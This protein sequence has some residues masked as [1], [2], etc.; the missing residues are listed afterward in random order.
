M[1]S[2][3]QTLDIKQSNTV[4]FVVTYSDDEGKSLSLE[5][6]TIEADIKDSSKKLVATMKVTSLSDTT[7]ELI[8]PDDVV[9]PL[10]TL[11]M[12]IRFIQNEVVRNSDIVQLNVKEVVT[13]G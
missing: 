4:S 11:Y 9:L 10:K 12:D 2:P 13:S 8:L 1:Y 5:G 3:K 6:V 7:F